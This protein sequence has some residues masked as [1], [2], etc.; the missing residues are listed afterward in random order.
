MPEGDGYEA[1]LAA[2]GSSLNEDERA[3]FALQFALAEDVA[4]KRALARS[5]FVPSSVEF[6]FHDAMCTLLEVQELVSTGSS[7]S[8]S[9]AWELLTTERQ[10][11]EAVE[12]VLRSA[13]ASRK[14]KR[15]QQRR[16][17]LELE[18]K[19]RLGKPVSDV[20]VRWL[21]G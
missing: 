7:A 21:S 16:L 5:R 10:R 20:T 17:L 13:S 12:Q 3:A 11:L 14:L 8:D 9:A 2:E 19:H 15:V 1:A 4:A 18:L 6:E